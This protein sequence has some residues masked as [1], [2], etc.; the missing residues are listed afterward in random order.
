MFCGCLKYVALYFIIFL[1]VIGISHAGTVTLTGTCQGAVRN[2]T[3]S[4]SLSNSG[5]DTAIDFSVVPVVQ[6][7]TVSGAYSINSLGP[8]ETYPLQIKLANITA[9]GTYDD[10]IKASYTQGG[11]VFSAVFPCQLV[12]GMPTRSVLALTAQVSNQSNGDKNI[13]INLY[14]SGNSSVLANVSLIAP[15][16]FEFAGKN[17]QMVSIPPFEYGQLSFDVRI[18][19]TGTNATYEVA[20]TAGYFAGGLHYATLLNIA[21]SET[22]SRANSGDLLLYMSIAAI[23]ILLALAFIAALRK[24]RKKQILLTA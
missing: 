1:A 23:L 8:G 7:A 13:S 11:S 4:F 17:S 5:N 3:L 24:R 19:E 12:F 18:P 2:N 9:K 10:Y 15:P 22:G 20:A 6:D 16:S 14:N 21:V